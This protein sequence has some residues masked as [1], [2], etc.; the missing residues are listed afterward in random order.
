MDP[1]GDTPSPGCGRRFLRARLEAYRCG[2]VTST[3]IH[4]A[5][6]VA[7][8]HYVLDIEIVAMLE[9]FG[10]AWNRVTD[11]IHARCM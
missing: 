6:S 8:L 7:K 3:Q 10:L 4:S 9:S 1:T 2:A 5:I 11:V